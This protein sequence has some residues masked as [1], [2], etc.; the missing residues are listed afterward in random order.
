[1]LDRTAIDD[2][3]HAY[4]RASGFRPGDQVVLAANADGLHAAALHLA[5]PGVS[6]R[7]KAGADGA[8]MELLEVASWAASS[9]RFDRV[10]LGSGDRIFLAALD[11]LRIRDI[12][13]DVVSRRN[14]MAAALA[15]RAGGAMYL[16]D[17]M[18]RRRRDVAAETA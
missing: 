6:H 18:R 11:E 17:V 2:A 16:D 8:D 9:R 13:V 14:A 3:L 7:W 1:M 4:R 10:V 15:I 5:W 12:R